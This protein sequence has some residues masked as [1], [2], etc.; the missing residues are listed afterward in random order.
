MEV[1][2]KRTESESQ[3][4]YMS[5]LSPDKSHIKGCFPAMRLT[6]SRKNKLISLMKLLVNRIKIFNLMRAHQFHKYHI[7]E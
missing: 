6:Y 4:H 1:F 7:F 3:M 5:R 2:K